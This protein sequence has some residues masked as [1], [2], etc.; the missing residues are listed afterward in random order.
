MAATGGPG[1]ADMVCV[2][3]RERERERERKKKGVF[4]A[5]IDS[6]GKSPSICLNARKICVIISKTKS[7]FEI[8]WND[9]SPLEM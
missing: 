5:Q 8:Y 7:A 3:E 2:R 1:L 4:T 6:V 9:V